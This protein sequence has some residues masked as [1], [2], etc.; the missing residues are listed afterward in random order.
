MA[1]TRN[2]GAV[3]RSGALDCVVLA[4]SNNPENSE[5]TLAAQVRFLAARHGVPAVRATTIA[6]LVFGEVVR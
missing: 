4:G 2:P 5:T 3:V 6:H 1:E